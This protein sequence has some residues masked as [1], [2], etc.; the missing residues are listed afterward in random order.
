MNLQFTHGLAS[1]ADGSAIARGQIFN[2]LRRSGSDGTRIGTLSI[3][4]DALAFVDSE[5]TLQ[6]S[7]V[8]DDDV[9]GRA[10]RCQQPIVF[11]AGAF[12]NIPSAVRQLQVIPIAV[13]HARQLGIVCHGFG[14]LDYPF[15][16]AVPATLY[17]I[18]TVA[19]RC[20]GYL[21]TAVEP[22]VGNV[23]T[24]VGEIIKVAEVGQVMGH[25]ACIAIL[26]DADDGAADIPRHIDDLALGEEHVGVR[27]VG[28]LVVSHDDEAFH[29][30]C[31][32]APD[33]GAITQARVAGD[34]G[35]IDADGAVVADAASPMED[36]GVAH[37]HAVRKVDLG[38]L[39]HIEATAV[40]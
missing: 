21:A 35:H 26:A 29:A 18:H 40:G 11:C 4:F 19:L 31:A 22:H 2:G 13:A 38:R 33:A 36:H 12:Y 10:R 1:G 34:D 28:F 23:G 30:E 7:S 17:V 37:D 39:I 15:I 14:G 6:T 25:D 27:S 3:D 5:T 20:E 16:A 24:V 32:A 9:G 8:A